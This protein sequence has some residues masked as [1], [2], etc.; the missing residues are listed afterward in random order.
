MDRKLFISPSPH[1][2]DADSIPKIMYAVVGAL[3]PAGIG[4]VY[5]FGPRVL[6]VISISVLTALLTEG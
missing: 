2:E 1:V 6:L 5:F 4:A 3:V